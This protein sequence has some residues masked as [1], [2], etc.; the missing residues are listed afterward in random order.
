MNVFT[1]TQLNEYTKALFDEDAILS[2]IT[3]SGELSNFK[4]HTSG[5]LYFSLKDDKCAIAGAMFKWQAAYLRFAP[6]NGMRV[7]VKGRV[8]LYEASGQYQIVVTSMYPDGIGALY[9]AFEAL[10][11][12]L[13]AEG[14]FAAERKKPIPMYPDRIGVVTSRTGAAFQDIKNVLGRRYPLAEVVLYPVLVQS[15]EAAGQM[16]HAINWLN[17]NHACDVIIIGRG[18]GSAEDLWSFNDEALARAVAA[19]EIPIISAVGHEIDFSI[20]D[21]VA[22][23]R[24]PTPSAAA[25]LAVPNS[26][27]LLDRIDEHLNRI[28]SAVQSKLDINRLK[29]RSVTSSRALSSQM[30]QIELRSQHIDMLE[31]RLNALYK[32]IISNGN[33]RL[34]ST[35]ARLSALDPMKV[36]ARGYCAASHGEKYISSALQLHEN[37]NIGLKFADGSV[38]C[39][40]NSTEVKNG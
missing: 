16:T 23:L 8:T 6:A 32:N 4:R 28:H 14:L 18:G 27:E 25:E 39:T 22:D 2:E 17:N 1:V 24:A 34:S 33:A 9:A 15:S 3:V 19:S 31:S 20:C 5:H 40:V 30:Y 13:A 29:L 10:R 21:F 37:D 35:A 38:F 7:I 26:D 11:K 12:K 36:L